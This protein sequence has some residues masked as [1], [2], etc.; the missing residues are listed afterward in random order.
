[1]FK[2]YSNLKR[3]LLVSKNLKDFIGLLHDDYKVRPLHK[4]LPKASAYA[5]DVFFDLR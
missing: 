4:M 1:M 2:K 3:F 5:I